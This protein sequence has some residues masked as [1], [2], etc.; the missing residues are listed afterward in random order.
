MMT[1]ESSRGSSGVLQVRTAPGERKTVK[2]R[3]M[4]AGRGQFSYSTNV[5]YILL[6]QVDARDEEKLMAMALLQPSKVKQREMHGLLMKVFV[7]TFVYYGGI[8]FLYINKTSNKS[9]ME[10]LTLEV[11]NLRSEAHD[12]SRVIYIEVPPQQSRLLNLT[13][14]NPEADII[15]KPKMTYYLQWV[16]DRYPTNQPHLPS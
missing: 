16:I 6:Q 2:Y 3:A 9:Y 10:D 12:L 11:N 14:I 1:T 13:A 15:Y 5:K 8:C 7:H 4:K